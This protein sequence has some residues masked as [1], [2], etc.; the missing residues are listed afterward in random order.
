MKCFQFRKWENNKNI[1]LPFDSILLRTKLFP[2]LAYDDNNKP[3]K[4]SVS[5][6]DKEKGVS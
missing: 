2:E 5:L 6:G 1:L 4:R 3:Q